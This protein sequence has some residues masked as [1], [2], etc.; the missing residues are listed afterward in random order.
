MKYSRSLIL[1]AIA[2]LFIYFVTADVA[3]AI[4]P[5]TQTIKRNISASFDH[6]R[7]EVRIYQDDYTVR[8][9]SAMEE[10]EILV[11]ISKHKRRNHPD[12]YL[13][14]QIDSDD[15]EIANKP[16][17]PNRLTCFN[18]KYEFY[19]T[20]NRPNEWQLSKFGVYGT[21]DYSEKDKKSHDDH[22]QTPPYDEHYRI[23]AL[24]ISMFFDNKNVNI[25]KVDA[26]SVNPGAYRITFEGKGTDLIPG[27]NIQS[28]IAGWLDASPSSNW[29]IIEMEYTTKTD[30]FKIKSIHRFTT[31]QIEN[32]IAV[33]RHEYSTFGKLGEKSVTNRIVTELNPRFTTDIDLSEF[34][35]S[36]YGLPEPVGVVP[37]NNN[38]NHNMIWIL[39]ASALFVLMSCVFAYL[40]RSSLSKTSTKEPE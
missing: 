13:L 1:N 3:L 11:S 37:L 18:P 16:R 29:S 28:S 33:V 31:K 19:L 10:K 22:L 8:T 20:A 9:Y 34:W 14:M 39:S 26:S 35:L 6:F 15:P 17:R 38:K 30:Q 27:A 2:A 12:G 24:P 23:G 25:L 4:E 40:R 5:D 7:T 36:K 32:L 21:D